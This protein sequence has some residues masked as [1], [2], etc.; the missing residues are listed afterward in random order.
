VAGN[1]TERLAK[2]IEK[3]NRISQISEWDGRWRQIGSLKHRLQIPM[4]LNPARF[5]AQPVTD[6]SSAMFQKLNTL[7]PSVL[8]VLI[9]LKL[10]E[11]SELDLHPPSRIEKEVILV[12]Q[13]R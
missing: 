6:V 13:V 8:S 11:V 12:S 5:L 9:V 3:Q 1:G 4:P 10:R 7:I 2:T